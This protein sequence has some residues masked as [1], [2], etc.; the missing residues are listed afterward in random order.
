MKEKIF[1]NFSLKI[2]SVLCA[3]VLW[4][5]IV[6]IY[7]PTTSVTISNVNVE[8]INAQSL[9]DKDYTYEVVDGSKISVYL[10]GPKSV[11][12]DIKSSDI[13][14]TADLSKISAFADYV[15]I[16]VKVVKDGKEVTGI[17]VTPR[18]TA[19]KLD[20]ENRL[21]K[22]YT[23]ETDTEGMPADGYVLT[24]VSVTPT[25]VKVTGPS[26][27]VEN[28]DKVKAVWD[29]S[30]AYSNVNSTAK[31]TAYAADGSQI[32]EEGFSFSKSDVDYTALISAHKIV[33]VRCAGT[34]GTVKDGY[35][36]MG[37][38]LSTDKAELIGD[39]NTLNNISEIVIPE[40]A[41]NVD[42]VDSSRNY[43]VW[44]SDYISQDLKVKSE[45]KL[46]IKVK[47]ADLNSREFSFDTSKI[48]FNN[49][50]TGYHVTIDDDSV[51]SI[52]ISGESSVLDSISGDNIKGT[53]N[54]TA[55]SAG[56]HTVFVNFTVPDG[57]KVVGE[58]KIQVLIEADKQQ[59][60]TSAAS[61]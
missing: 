49:I 46:N 38:E 19:V 16:D 24:S 42:N 39:A 4:A 52:V 50:K 54:L 27:I 28:I 12:T 5:V 55:L 48:T 37:I 32:N 33:N 3:I 15:D 13:V 21:T 34:T 2:L 53:T 11:I 14:A 44:L 58:Y 59:E 60:T 8:L 30:G 7:D 23:I 61:N 35:M 9:T 31:L 41:I 18:T 36:I 57:C 17:E 47:V 45:N 43:T 40:S 56:R 6:N 1:N 25:T 29:I 22:E 26:S 10:S 51:M 20:I